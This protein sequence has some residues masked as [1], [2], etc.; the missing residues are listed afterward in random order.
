MR[1]HIAVAFSSNRHH[2]VR[3]LPAAKCPSDERS[4]TDWFPVHVLMRY[5]LTS[6]STLE[7]SLGITTISVFRFCLRGLFM[8]GASILRS[9]PLAAVGRL[10]LYESLQHCDLVLIL[11]GCE[12]MLICRSFFSCALDV[13]GVDLMVLASLEKP[14]YFCLLLY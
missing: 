13:H 14:E 12:L 8:R 7:D 10:I 11:S 2:V 3:T 5:L 6:F 1:I 9:A 4:R